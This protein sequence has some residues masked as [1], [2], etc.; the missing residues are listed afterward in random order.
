MPDGFSYVF[1]QIAVLLVL[2]LLVGVLIGRLLRPRRTASPAADQ[3]AAEAASSGLMTAFAG[4][5]TTPEA[6]GVADP[7]QPPGDAQAA[8]AY[9]QARIAQAEG[10]RAELESRLTEAQA[11]LARTTT[12]LAGLQ[13]QATQAR[14]ELQQTRIRLGDAEATLAETRRQLTEAD[15]EV[16]RLRLQARELVDQKELEMGR[17]ESG[18][19]AA[20]ESTISAHQEQVTELEAKLAEATRTAQEHEREVAAEHR[21][22]EQLQAALAERDQHLA[23]LAAARPPSVP[24]PE[25]GVEHTTTDAR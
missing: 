11:Q 12:G 4:A 19:I 3:V 22:A 18:A 14:T 17:L 25:T 2:A 1:G 6:P 8:S 20:L 5:P 21:R 15:A 16:V 7:L 9:A 13:G 24:R 10:R 23:T